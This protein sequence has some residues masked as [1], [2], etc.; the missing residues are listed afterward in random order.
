MQLSPRLLLSH[1]LRPQSRKLLYLSGF[2]SWRIFQC[3]NECN[4]NSWNPLI[5]TINIHQITK[6][7]NQYQSTS[8]YRNKLQGTLG[9][10]NHGVSAESSHSILI[11]TIQIV[12]FEMKSAFLYLCQFL[13][14]FVNRGCTQSYPGNIS[15]KYTGHRIDL[16]ISLKSTN[17]Y[18]LFGMTGICHKSRLFQ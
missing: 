8:P 18:K 17:I 9:P 2:L 15:T 4:S 13:R 7:R 10:V 12:S 6:T 14:P 1:E 3:L 11:S 16:N 5:L